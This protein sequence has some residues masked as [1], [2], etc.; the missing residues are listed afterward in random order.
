[1]AVRE[2]TFVAGEKERSMVRSREERLL[3]RGWEKESSEKEA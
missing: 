1:M 3:T 2:G